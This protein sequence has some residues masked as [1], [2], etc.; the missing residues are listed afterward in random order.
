MDHAIGS[1]AGGKAPV[2]DF[3]A[4]LQDGFLRLRFPDEMEARFQE[5]TSAERVRL[6]RIGAFLGLLLACGLLATDWI[7]VPDRFAAATQWRLLFL[8]PL[9]GLSAAFLQMV[10][11]LWQDRSG[12]IN[13]LLSASVHSYL[14]VS[15]TDELAGPYLVTLSMI[16]LFNGGVTRM[17]FWRALQIDTVVLGLFAWASMNIP[18]PNIPVMVGQALIMVSTTVF[19]LYNSYSLE[20]E[21][22]TNW[23]MRQHEHQLLSKL[24]RG[25]H[26]LDQITRFDPLTEI[27][28]RR[29]FDEFVAQ[30]WSRCA[31]D[32]TAVAVLMMDIDHFKL[33]NDHYGHPVG[34]ACLKEVAATLARS[35]RRP[36]DLVARFGGEEF[37]AVLSR[38][39]LAEALAAAERVRLAVWELARPHRAS[40][41]QDRVT[42]SIGVA[43]LRA[44]EPGASTIRLLAQ[45]D[46]ALY[47]AKANGRNLARAFGQEG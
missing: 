34:D 46:E 26:R 12:L 37:I 40:L 7:M 31:R 11:P 17:R 24:E 4:V 1:D 14:C 38:T 15:S 19:T 47:Q 20:R 28:N 2:G 45:A 13:S 3:E 21:E 33:Y 43:C 25:N 22:R 36:G 18:N 23:L 35:L 39:T 41:T 29:H 9:L 30:V 42:I 44:N 10:P 8:V 5:D 27:A 6:L 32:G 16:V